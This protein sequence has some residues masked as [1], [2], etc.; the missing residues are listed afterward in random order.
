M[1]IRKQFPAALAGAIALTASA[2][3]ALGDDLNQLKKD[4]EALEARIEEQSKQQERQPAPAAGGGVHISRGDALSD[5]KV[6]RAKDI[7]IPADSGWT[8]SIP[9]SSGGLPATE[10][11]ISGYVRAGGSVGTNPR[12]IGDKKATSFGEGR[13][14]VRSRSQTSVG[15]VRMLYD[16]ELYGKERKS[17]SFWEE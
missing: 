6:D 9:S 15:E 1:L 3:L 5:W 13:F 17:R 8:V 7:K 11:S 16:S 14:R 2:S 4:I 12:G 10:L